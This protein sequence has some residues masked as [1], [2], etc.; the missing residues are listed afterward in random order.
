MVRLSANFIKFYLVLKMVPCAA[1]KVNSNLIFCVVYFCVSLLTLHK[2][3]YIIEMRRDVVDLNPRARA[4][5]ILEAEGYQF[6]RHGA[7]HDIYYNPKWNHRM[8]MKR[9]SF[10]ENDIRNMEREI[11]RLKD[12]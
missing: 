1:G 11:K 12:R 7:N 2:I 3:V 10:S 8:A 9:H 6:V 5:K 4:L